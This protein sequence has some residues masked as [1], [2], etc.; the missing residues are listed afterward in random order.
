M[1]DRR[2]CGLSLV[3]EA[4]RIDA[5]PPEV[6]MR[7]IAQLEDD[8]G[9]GVV[10]Q[11]AQIG[12]ERG[13]EDH[14]FVRTRYAVADDRVLVRNHSQAPSRCIGSATP[15][16]RHLRRRL[17]L[18]AATERASRDARRKRFR[19]DAERVGA[20]RAR[21]REDDAV[22]GELVDEKLLHRTVRVGAPRRVAWLYG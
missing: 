2:A 7:A 10:R 21:R 17:V 20:Q 19:A 6:E 16:P 5:T 4:L 15:A 22:A 13:G 1:F 8:V 12:I 9:R 14:D 11:C 18:V 3:Y